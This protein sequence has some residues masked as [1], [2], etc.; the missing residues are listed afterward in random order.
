MEYVPSG[1]TEEQALTAVE[2]E[3][4]PAGHPKHTALEVPDKAVDDVP[5]GHGVSAVD[6]A[7]QKFP[8]VHAEVVE[9]VAQ[10]DPAEQV[11]AD[12]EVPPAQ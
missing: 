6:P 10:Y 12:V 3:Y 5:A 1:Q 8:A 9:V 11:T 7:G 4:L 2:P